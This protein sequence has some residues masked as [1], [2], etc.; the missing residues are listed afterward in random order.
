MTRFHR[1]RSDPGHA[2]DQNK[3]R[4]R[5]DAEAGRRRSFCNRQDDA[6]FGYARSRQM[7]QRFHP[8][9]G[10]QGNGRRTGMNCRKIPGSKACA[11]A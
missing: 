10:G 11:N 3:K 6:I 8:S 7:Q 2:P 9:T 1:G 4:K 5:T